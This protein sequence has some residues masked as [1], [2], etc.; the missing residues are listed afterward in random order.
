MAT[1]TEQAETEDFVEREVRYTLDLGNRL[2]VVENVP[3]RVSRQTGEQ[4][5]SPETTQ[6]LRDIVHGGE[7]PARV[8]ETDVYD[9]H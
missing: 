8:M 1:E 5:F 9:F 7:Q 6:R 3:A 2:V 4:C